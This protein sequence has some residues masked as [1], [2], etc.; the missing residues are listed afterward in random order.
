MEITGRQNVQSGNLVVE[1]I[2]GDGQSDESC[3]CQGH[4]MEW[5]LWTGFERRFEKGNA[6]ERG[7]HL[8]DDGVAQQSKREPVPPGGNSIGPAGGDGEDADE[9]V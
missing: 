8:G 7:L 3:F 2:V 6:I 5:I 9:S 4:S 1:K